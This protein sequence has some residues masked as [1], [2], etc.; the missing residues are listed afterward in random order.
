MIGRALCGVLE[1]NDLDAKALKQVK[2]AVEKDMR[3]LEYLLQTNTTIALNRDAE[4]YEVTSDDAKLNGLHGTMRE[5]I[6]GKIGRVLTKLKI[7]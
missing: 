1:E 3:W 6:L 4:R 2:K 7:D 5:E